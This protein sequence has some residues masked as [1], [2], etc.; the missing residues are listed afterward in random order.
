VD[1]P[2]KLTRA[3][4][5][6]GLVLALA[7]G[8]GGSGGGSEVTTAAA[9][10]ATQTGGGSPS[11]AVKDYQRRVLDAI[12]AMGQF[13][14]TLSKVQAGNLKTLAPAFAAQAATF[15]NRASVVEQLTPP[16]RLRDAHR[17]LVAALEAVS[18]SMTDLSAAAGKGDSAA[19][20]TADDAFVKASEK[21]A[22][23]GQALQAA[24]G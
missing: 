12:S 1:R 2:G 24:G 16:A 18:S 10:T 7:A 17:R 21:L 14:Q 5:G 3:L 8:C 23:A 9:T 22:A 20:L 19:F 4:A 13:G 11:L 15:S 6:A